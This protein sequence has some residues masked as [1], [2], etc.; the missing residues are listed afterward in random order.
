MNLLEVK[1]ISKYYR[2][3]GSG[4]LKVLENINFNIPS[5]E[6]GS[7]ISI[8][9]PFGAGKSTLMKVISSVVLPDEGNILLNGKEYSGFTGGIIYLPERPVSFPW[10]S[11]R[12]NIQMALNLPVNKHKPE[13]TDIISLIGLNGYE[14]HFPDNFSYGF[15][16]RISLGRA[17]AVNPE[18]ILID[19]SFKQMDTL[20]RNEMYDLIRKVSSVT[21]KTFILATTSISE[22]A[23][24]SRRIFFMKKNP[25]R[26]FYDLSVSDEK[27]QDKANINLI[28]EEIESIYKKENLT[29]TIQ[30]MI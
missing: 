10:L 6:A 25:G 5:E 27:I 30:I 4:T 22:A 24:I 1:N 23:S 11:V 14:D 17:I 2:L 26:I 15:R 16:F 19:D 13:I 28:R 29:D 12:G 20:T 21:G 9:A 18:I 3:Y 7:I 8:I